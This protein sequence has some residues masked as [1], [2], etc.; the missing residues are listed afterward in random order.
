MLVFSEP[1]WPITLSLKKPG[2]VWPAFFPSAKLEPS[3][4]SI[5]NRLARRLKPGRRRSPDLSGTRC[6]ERLGRIDHKTSGPA[7]NGTIVIK[8]RILDGWPSGLRHRS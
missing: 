7:T 3:E 2:E 6:P 1:V 8:N 4:G 5:E